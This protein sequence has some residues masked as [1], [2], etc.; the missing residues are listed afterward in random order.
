MKMKETLTKPDFASKLHALLE[1]SAMLL[2]SIHT[3]WYKRLPKNNEKRKG[4]KKAVY[5]SKHQPKTQRLIRSKKERILCIQLWICNIQ[6]T[7]VDISNIEY[8]FFYSFRHIL[9]R[10]YSIGYYLW[11]VGEG[12]GE[13]E[14][15]VITTTCDEQDHLLY[16]AFWLP[17]DCPWCAYVL[18]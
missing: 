11:Y 15:D 16:I 10:V 1:K 18:A 5:D 17:I 13:G 4:R 9:S 6:H 14:G 7:V 8:Q 3:F 2:G 12:E